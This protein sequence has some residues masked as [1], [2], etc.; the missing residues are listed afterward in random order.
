MSKNNL[1]FILSWHH[2]ITAFKLFCNTLE[3]KNL[4]RN[5]NSFMSWLRTKY[6]SNFW[7]PTVTKQEL[8]INKGKYVIGLA[9]SLGKATWLVEN[10]LKCACWR[11]LRNFHFPLLFFTSR[12]FSQRCKKGK[13]LKP[14]SSFSRFWNSLNKKSRWIVS[15]KYSNNINFWGNV[16]I[17]F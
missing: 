12:R 15:V 1:L 9:A 4:I 13:I 17:I 3:I 11:L 6:L 5:S 14:I 8:F 2:T 16:F 10:N 7:N